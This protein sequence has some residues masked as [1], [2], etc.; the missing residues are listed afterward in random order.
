MTHEK[1]ITPPPLPFIAEI[2][3]Q[4]QRHYS[5][6]SIGPQPHRKSAQIFYPCLRLEGEPFPA[7]S[8]K[9]MLPFVGQMF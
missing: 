5:Q 8:I 7:Q 9:E 6:G 2:R 1:L 4:V 3:N